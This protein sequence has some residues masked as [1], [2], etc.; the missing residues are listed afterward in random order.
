[1]E[2]TRQQQVPSSPTLI[3]T[4]RSG[5]PSPRQTGTDVCTGE[6]A[7]ELPRSLLEELEDHPPPDVKRTGQGRGLPGV[8]QRAHGRLLPKR[9]IV[10]IWPGCSDFLP[11]R[12][13]ASPPFSGPKGTHNGDVGGSNPPGATRE[14]G[15]IR[16]EFPSLPV[17][18]VYLGSAPFPRVRTST[19]AH[20]SPKSGALSCVKS[21]LL[22]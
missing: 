8:Y 18:R 7:L 11:A 16:S 14:I 15:A 12:P 22:L 5:E 17:F 6:A 10:W 9:G 1:M 3:T 4:I 13:R 2:W 20:P 19:Q 21:G